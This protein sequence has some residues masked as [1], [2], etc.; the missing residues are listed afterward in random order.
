[1]ERHRRRGEL[2]RFDII[3][4]RRDETAGDGRR[5]EEGMGSQGGRGTAISRQSN[6]QSRV[7]Q[8]ALCGCVVLVYIRRYFFRKIEEIWAGWLVE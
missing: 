7:V 8:E 5:Y 4:T 3:E 1:M 2:R 6:V